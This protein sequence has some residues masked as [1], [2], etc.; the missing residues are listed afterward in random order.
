MAK[1][2]NEVAQK[3][4]QRTAGATDA[5]RRGV[6]AVREAP[7]A[8]AA[9]RVDAMIQRLMELRDSG[10]LQRRMESVGVEEWR[11]MTLEKGPE[12]LASGVRAAQPKMTEFLKEF[13]PY[14]ENVAA[15]LPPRGSFEDNVNR[16]VENARRLREFKRS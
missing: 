9:Q 14:A 4:A 8:K 2:P 1:N 5:Y 10:E 12:R 11:R 6:E 7:G 16:M 15:S 3:W 13:L